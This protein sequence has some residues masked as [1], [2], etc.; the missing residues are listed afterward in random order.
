MEK[1]VNGSVTKL[2]VW[3]V[4]QPTA[5]LVGYRPP[6]CESL[7]FH[8]GDKLPASTICLLIRTQDHVCLIVTA[9]QSGASRGR[10]GDLEHEPILVGDQEFQ[11]L[12]AKF[13]F[14]RL[15]LVVRVG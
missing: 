5:I 11:H 12:L 6:S 8:P 1:Q 2:V 13:M 14:F 3:E 15:H 9:P 10:W 7:L 4:Q